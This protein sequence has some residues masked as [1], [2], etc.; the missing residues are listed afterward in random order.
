[1]KMHTIQNPHKL[2]VKEKRIP[3]TY[4]L[5]LPD[6]IDK[7]TIPIIV[8]H[9][10]GDYANSNYM[11]SLH[12]SLSKYNVSIITINYV[13]TFTKVTLNKNDLSYPF[14]EQSFQIEDKKDFLKFLKAII[15]NPVDMNRV[16]KRNDF[17]RDEIDISNYIIEIKELF[18]YIQNNMCDGMYIL[19]SLEKIGFKS[20]FADFITDTKGDHQDFGLIQAID[21]LTVV[22]DLKQN[23]KYKNIN[24]SKLSIVGSSHGGYI[25]SMCDKLAPNTFSTVVNNSG[26]IKAYIDFPYNKTSGNY[27]TLKATTKDNNYWSKDKNDKN[28]LSLDHYEIRDLSHTKHLKK[29]LKI[30]DNIKSCKYIFIHTSEDHL[31]PINE[32]DKY[33]KELEEN[34][35]D[36]T[37]IRLSNL[38][39]LDGKTFKNLKHG[40]NASIKGLVI[41]YII[42]NRYKLNTIINNDF[43]LNSKIK[44]TCKNGKYI[45]NYKN[46]YPKV[47]FNKK[48]IE[49]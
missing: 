4:F 16:L 33:I 46:K 37:Y 17:I 24:W 34:G 8:L 3:L 6:K 25:A 30:K 22:A 47:I 31:I 27:A 45:I 44:Y 39:Q 38:S 20:C 7:N 23:K 14:L 11:I 49:Y 5:S 15:V 10:F 1:M 43:D 12:K 32:K 9:G 13:G 36:I 26:W 29:H 40:A 2:E 18:Y 28:F 35:Y 19:N 42:K 41:D 48:Y 21:V